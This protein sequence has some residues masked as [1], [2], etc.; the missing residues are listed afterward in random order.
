M[1]QQI[2][3]S[4]LVEICSEYNSEHSRQLFTISTSDL[5]AAENQSEEVEQIYPHCSPPPQV[6][7][8][9]CACV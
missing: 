8:N 4:V 9:R 3:C 2:F 7:P 6:I 1:E 5:V